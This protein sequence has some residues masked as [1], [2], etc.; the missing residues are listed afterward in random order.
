MADFVVQA[1]QIYGFDQSRIVAVGFSNGANLAAGML[2]LQPQCIATAVLLHP[3]L[4]FRPG[5]LPNLQGKSVFIGAGL[6]DALVPTDQPE[7]LADLLRQ[8]GANVRLFW[9]NGG[10]SVSV[11]EVKA[12]REW[13]A[14][15]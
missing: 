2:F 10:H 14:A 12:A 3:M 5:T 11:E 9:H 8:A 4:P 13:L 6:T 1:S 7:Q 15:V